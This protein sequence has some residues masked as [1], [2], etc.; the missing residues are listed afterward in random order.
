MDMITKFSGAIVD[1]SGNRVPKKETENYS[2]FT[3]KVGGIKELLDIYRV[4]DGSFF[5]EHFGQYP[6]VYNIL[7]H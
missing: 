3:D 6:V 7:N 5:E 2:V 4:T 1:E